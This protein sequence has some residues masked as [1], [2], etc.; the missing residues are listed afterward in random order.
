MISQSTSPMN[1]ARFGL[2]LMV[3][4]SAGTLLLQP[5][6]GETTTFAKLKE[7]P[8]TQVTITDTFWAPRQETNR[9][10]TIPYNLDMLEKAGN[11]HNF[12]LAATGAHSG[13]SGPVY[14]DSDL[15]KGLEAASYSLA[16]H[17]DP[18]LEGRLDAIIARVAAAQRP[19]GYLDTHFEVNAPDKRRTNLRDWHELYCAGHL[20]EAAVAHYQATGKRTLLDVAVRYA[21]YIGSVFG[22]GPGKRMGYPGH[23]EIELALVKLWRVTGEHRYFD[24]ARFF[25]ES[26]GRKFFAEEHH[27][28]LDKYDGTYWQDDVPIRDHQCIN[29]HAV[30]AAYLLS[31]AVDVASETG[32]QGLLDMISRVWYNTTKRR[33]YITGGIGPSASNE[34]FTTDYDLPNLTAY[35]ETCASVA[36]AMWNHRL[37]LLY[38]DGRYADLVERALYNGILAGVSLDGTRFF[39]ANPLASTGKDHRSSWF[40][41]A[42]CPPNVTRTIASL[43]GYAYALSDHGIWVNLYVQGSVQTTLDHEPVQLDV[44]TDYPWNGRVIIKPL[45]ENPATFELR[46]RIPGWCQNAVASVNGQSVSNPTIDRDY[47]VLA[48]EWHEGD[49]IELNLPMPVELIAANPLVKEDLG[50]LAVQRGPIVYCLEACDQSVPLSAI[51]LPDAARLTPEKRSGLLGGVVVLK[52]RG[53][54][55]RALKWDNRLYQAVPDARRVTIT[56][57]PYYAWDN[58]AP[59]AMEV[60]IPVSPLAAK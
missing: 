25:V 20:F 19:D 7:V 60:W 35:Q 32:D 54:V 16:T 2:P 10:A 1:P 44:T 48:R 23:P 8:F 29:G 26:R 24:L 41:C 21:D 49:V 37:N 42:C 4:L 15:Y 45:L 22:N 58:R 5:V 13:Y 30:R 46:L 50:K 31:G 11:I 38:G 36:M 18:A 39:Y 55:A 12:D 51:A 17:P 43:G 28:P 57:I 40:G 59:G 14:M 52:G 6:R 3:W 33:M 56:A 9:L 47:L 53:R 34:G 27:T